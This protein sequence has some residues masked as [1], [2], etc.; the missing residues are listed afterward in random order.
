MIVTPQ[1]CPHWP[2]YSFFYCQLA[3]CV[4]RHPV[5]MQS[6]GIQSTT[7][8]DRGL[9][10]HIASHL[11]PQAWVGYESGQL[12]V[13]KF[14]H[15][16]RSIFQVYAMLPDTPP[17][18]PVPG[19]PAQSLPPPPL[20]GA[21]AGS[22]LRA[23]MAAALGSAPL[24]QVC[25]RGWREGVGRGVWAAGHDSLPCTHSCVMRPTLLLPVPP[26]LL[27][28]RHPFTPTMLAARQVHAGCGLVAAIVAHEHHVVLAGESTSSARGL[29]GW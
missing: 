12:R 29:G 3:A 23:S 7:C 21:G 18:M 1:G 15:V 13:V 8:I 11:S 9:T 16:R 2:H 14:D 17:P 24:V 4:T 10:A 6:P 5:N 25:Q 20:G 28:Q 26:S 22:G 19:A 27:S